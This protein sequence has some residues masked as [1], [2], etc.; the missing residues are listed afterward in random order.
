MVDGERHH[1]DGGQEPADGDAAVGVGQGL[2]GPGVKRSADGEVALQRDGHQREAAHRHRH[3][4]KHTADTH[5]R[6][7]LMC[8]T[9]L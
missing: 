7:C 9:L 8:I 4:C 5:E 2:P 1:E 6:V 3:A